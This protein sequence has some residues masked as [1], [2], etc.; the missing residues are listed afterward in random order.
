MK[1][2]TDDAYERLQKMLGDKTKTKVVVPDLKLSPE[3]KNA[4]YVSVKSKLNA[5][6]LPEYHAALLADSLA[7]MMEEIMLHKSA[8]VKMEEKKKL[9]AKEEDT[10][11]GAN[12]GP[13][14]SRVDD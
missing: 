11:Y 1:T 8:E 2:I 14:F 6:N 13:V 7:N 3:D 9:S 12:L 10:G 5:F 4:L